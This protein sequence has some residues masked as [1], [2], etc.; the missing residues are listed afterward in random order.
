MYPTKSH[1]DT[2]KSH[3]D[4]SCIFE[5]TRIIIEIQ[6]QIVVLQTLTYPY[7]ALLFEVYGVF[8]VTLTIIIEY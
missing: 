5:D 1:S 8:I 6:G 2:L 7:Q 3:P 4:A